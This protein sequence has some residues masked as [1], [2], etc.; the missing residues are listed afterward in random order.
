MKVKYH[1][2]A[3]VEIDENEDDFNE[4]ILNRI[5]ENYKYLDQHLH[6]LKN[7]HVKSVQISVS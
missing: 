7:V 2:Y 3:I 4:Q 1:I 6:D 5:K